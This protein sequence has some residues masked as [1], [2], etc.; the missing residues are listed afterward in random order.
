MPRRNDLERILLIGAGPIVIGQ[1]CEFDYSGTQGAKSLRE[2]GYDVVGLARGKG[3]LDEV[4]SDCALVILDIA[5]EDA[6]GVQVCRDLKAQA[7]TRHI[8]ILVMTAMSGDDVR[9]VSLAAGADGY[10][11]KPF[12]VDDLL[13]EV[14]RQLPPPGERQVPIDSPRRQA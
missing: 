8:P 6:D 7:R 9:Q 13:K 3:A 4:P 10:L 12:G 11:V 1:G 14:R 5:L 2:E